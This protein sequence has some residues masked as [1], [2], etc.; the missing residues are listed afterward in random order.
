MRQSG[1]LIVISTQQDRTH[2]LKK[3]S[4]QPI[5]NDERKKRKNKKEERDGTKE[6]EEENGRGRFQATRENIGQKAIAINC[7]VYIRYTPCHR[8]T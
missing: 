8:L 2:K 4:Q 3:K 1:C 7:C 6:E 5:G